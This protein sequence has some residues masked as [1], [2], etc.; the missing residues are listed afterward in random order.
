MHFPLTVPDLLVDL[1]SELSIT[2][3]LAHKALIPS[4]SPMYG[5]VLWDGKEMNK[6]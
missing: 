6:G 3:T 1:S 2:Q 4:H 5:K